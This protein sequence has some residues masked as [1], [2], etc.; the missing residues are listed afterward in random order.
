MMVVQL[1]RIVYT[2][3]KRVDHVSEVAQERERCNSTMDQRTGFGCTSR[4]KICTS[5]FRLVESGVKSVYLGDNSR[6]LGGCSG[7][8]EK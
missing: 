5:D 3:E 4:C 2:R 1:G 7:S 6:A 8:Q